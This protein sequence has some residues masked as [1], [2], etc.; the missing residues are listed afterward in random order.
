MKIIYCIA[1]LRHSGGM[2]RVLTAKVNYLVAHGVEVVIVTTN[3]YGEPNFFPLLPK[4]RTID[5]GINYEE[6]NGKSISNKLLHYPFKQFKH[7]K[8]IAGLLK[9]EKA[10]IVVSMFCNDASFLWKVK[11][12]SKK[13]LEIHFSRFKRLQYGRKGLWR[14]AD[15]LR[16]RMDLKTV[17]RYD[18]FVVLTEEDKVY[19]GDLPNMEVI[20]NART[21]YP[22]QTSSL[23]NKHVIA[24]GRYDYQK[25]FDELISAWKI[26]NETFSDWKLSIFGNGELREALQ[27]QIDG[28]QLSAKIE[29]RQPV[30]NIAE[31]YLQSSILA[32]SSRYE[33]LPMVLLEAQAFGL[34]IV[35]YACKCGPRDVITNEQDGILVSEGNVSELAQSLMKLMADEILRKKMGNQARINSDKFAEPVIM[36]KWLSLFEELARK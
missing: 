4:V 33:G 30:K 28:N 14:L 3:Q 32:M 11:D 13:V 35:S 22:E 29:L 1:G 8:R 31:E 12:G 6:N 34:P 23:E 20:P 36:G 27:K 21:F 25:G 15:S 19:W 7:K 24:V 18:K 9:K 5:L 10:D 2:E 26:V 17:A 16:S